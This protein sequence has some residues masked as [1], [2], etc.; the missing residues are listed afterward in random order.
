MK[1]SKK[2]K[3]QKNG[4]YRVSA[5]IPLEK[6]F[7]EADENNDPLKWKKGDK[8]ETEGEYSLCRCGKSKNKPFCDGAHVKINFDGTET[9]SKEKYEKQAEIISGPELDL[10]DA[11]SFCSRARF[12]HRRGG[13]WKLT[14]ESNDPEAKET[15][16]E[17]ACNCC[18][19]RLTAI[20]KKTGEEIERDCEA[21][22][23]V[24][25]DIPAGVSGPLW[26]K[27]GIAIESSD[28]SV[29]EVRNRQALC[30]CG[31]SR[32]KP[33][34]DGSHIDIGFDDRV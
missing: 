2:I 22:I 16:I 4:P 1:E 32:N 5:D 24:T 26:A 18:S 12:C 28:G 20:D 34:C 10:M 29:Y 17:E 8:Y 14:Q 7:V 13:T 19:G 23:S 11:E 33:F 30:R 9:A 15:A 21:S 25:E 31:K 6:E 27:G 3:I